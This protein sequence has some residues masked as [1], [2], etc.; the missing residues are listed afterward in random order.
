MESAIRKDYN[1]IVVAIKK[2][3]G[4]MIF[5]PSPQAKLHVGDTL[6]VLGIEGI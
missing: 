3:S 5:N 1:L 4:E 2:K 6:V